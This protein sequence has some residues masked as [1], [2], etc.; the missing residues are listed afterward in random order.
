MTR[1]SVPMLIGGLAVIVSALSGRSLVAGNEGPSFSEG[2]IFPKLHWRYGWNDGALANTT[3]S[4]RKGQVPPSGTPVLPP[5]GYTPAQVAHAYGFDT[6]IAAG[7]NGSNRTI[8]IVV[9]YGCPTL[10]ND[11]SVFCSQF[12]L[13]PAQLN[14]VAPIGLPPRKVDSAWASETVMD[15][16]WAHAMA[17][18]ARLLVVVSPD[19][20]TANLNSCI[21][22]ADSRADVV[23]MSWGGVESP[24]D[25]MSHSLFTNPAVTFVAAAGDTGAQ[26]VE[27][28]AVDPSVLGVGGTSLILSGENAI[29][30]ETAWNYGS[31]GVSRYQQIPSYQ[32]GWTA[33]SGRS[34][35]DV[36]CLADPYTGVYVYETDARR[37]SGG[38]GVYGGTSAGT[39]MWAALLADRM[40]LGKDSLSNASLYSAV[41][42]GFS[43]GLYIQDMTYFR[44]ITQPQPYN[45]EKRYSAYQPAPGFDLVTGLG[46]P[47]SGAFSGLVGTNIP[48]APAPSPT[49]TP[50]QP[51]FGGGWWWEGGR[52]RKK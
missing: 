42:V 3:G 39:P 22:Y 1:R 46:S 27:W 28:P 21:Q 6:M 49:A 30:S 7:G 33:V 19:A 48:P 44:D 45:R 24:A 10:T 23:S 34:V 40:S 37:R 13:P 17:P 9:A 11:L 5:G 50:T 35:P 41:A 52:H 43:G 29:T 15:V 47:A 16:E 12:N 2:R 14:V 36:S 18:A 31:G 51:P 20:S 4:A 32:T 25:P 38:W 26:D 8:A